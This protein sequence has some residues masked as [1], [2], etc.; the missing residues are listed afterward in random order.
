[1][2]KSFL[3]A[4]VTAIS[5]M[6][7]CTTTSTPEDY[8][9]QIVDVVKCEIA[10][11]DYVVDCNSEAST[12]WGGSLSLLLGIEFAHF[13]AFVDFIGEMYVSTEHSYG[14]CLYLTAHDTECDFQNVARNILET[15][16]N[17]SAHLSEFTPVAT[18]ETYKSWSFYELRTNIEF[19]F[20]LEFNGDQWFYSTTVNQKSL[21]SYI[22]KQK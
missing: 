3:L 13:Q 15:Y 1:M 8:Y 14:D 19:L 21:N 4:L 20:A 12:V 5:L 18:H 6:Q 22:E 10:C 11:A 16:N 7:S 17:L 9:D 2:K